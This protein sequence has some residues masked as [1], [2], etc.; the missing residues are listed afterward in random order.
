MADKPHVTAKTPASNAPGQQRMHS[1]RNPST[2][3]AR[4]ITQ[5]QWRDRANDPSLTGFER[6]DDDDQTAEPPQGG[7][8]SQQ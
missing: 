6:V 7:T 3:E 1:V 5:E 2:G 8:T 4:Q